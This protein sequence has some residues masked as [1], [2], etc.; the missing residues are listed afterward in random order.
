MDQNN[1]LEPSPSTGLKLQQVDRRSLR[2]RLGVAHVQFIPRL[3]LDRLTWDVWHMSILPAIIAGSVDM[4]QLDPLEP[5]PP[6]DLKRRQVDHRSLNYRR[7]N[8]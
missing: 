5:S 6:T 4:D 3:S 7:A 1:P 2:C 8:V